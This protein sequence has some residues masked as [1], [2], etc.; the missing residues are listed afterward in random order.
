MLTDGQRKF[1]ENVAAGANGV[2]A[3]AAAFG[4]DARS[5]TRAKRRQL[6]KRASALRQKPTIAA[7]IERLRTGSTAAPGSAIVLD[8]PGLDRALLKLLDHVSAATL[9]DLGD[10]ELRRV[11]AVADHVAKLSALELKARAERLK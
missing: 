4:W 2:A 9:L 3:Y 6:A 10:D 11:S 1:A 7:L 8:K 5:V